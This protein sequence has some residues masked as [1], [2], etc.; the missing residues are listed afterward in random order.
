M[1][2]ATV[3]YI[4]IPTPPKAVLLERVHADYRKTVAEHPENRR[5]AFEYLEFRKQFIENLVT[6]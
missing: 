4:D 1:N 3:V 6:K 2:G 5:H